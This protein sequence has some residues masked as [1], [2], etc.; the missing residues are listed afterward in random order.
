MAGFCNSDSTVSWSLRLTGN[1]CW[2]LGRKEGPEEGGGAWRER[3]SSD[4]HDAARPLARSLAR[5]G[6]IASGQPD[7]A[8]S[9]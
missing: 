2:L 3:R 4:G 1:G 5:H 6:K 9:Q 8:P 7:H